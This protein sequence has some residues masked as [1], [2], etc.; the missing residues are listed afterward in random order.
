[1]ILHWVCIDAIPSPFACP[2]EFE[3]TLTVSAFACCYTG[4]GDCQ[5]ATRCENATLYYAGGHSP[6]AW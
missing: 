3:L 5:I 6:T 2:P 4:I 1:M